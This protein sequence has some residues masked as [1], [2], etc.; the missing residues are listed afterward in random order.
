MKIIKLLNFLM[1]SFNRNNCIKKPNHNNQ[2]QKKYN[3]NPMKKVN[4]TK[5]ILTSS[6]KK[7]NKNIRYTVNKKNSNNICNINRKAFPSDKTSSKKY[8]F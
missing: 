4:K 5:S 8:Y 7:E 6:Y 3:V 2:N 1:N